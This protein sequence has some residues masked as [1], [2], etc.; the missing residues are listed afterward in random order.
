MADQHQRISDSNGKARMDKPIPQAEEAFQ[1]TLGQEQVGADTSPTPLRFFG[2]YELVEEIARGGMGVVYK[3]RQVS[4]NRVVALKMILTGQLASGADVVRFRTEAEAVASL[5]HP[6]IVSVYEVGT[7]EEQHYFTM[8]LIDGGS[9]SESLAKGRWSIGTREGERRAAQLMA[10]VA[11]AVH[12]AHQRGILHRDIKP[13]NILLDEFGHPHITDFGVAKRVEGGSDLTRSGAIVGTPSYMAPEQARAEKGLST[14]VD[15]YSLGAVLFELLTGRPPFKGDSPLNTLRQVLDCEPPRPRQIQP[16]LNRDLE[17]ICLKCLEKEAPQRYGSAEAF[18]E[19]LERWLAEEPIRAR[20]SK[21]WERALKWARR[22]P[23]VAALMTVSS[24]GAILMI[25]LLVVSYIVVSREKQKADDALERERRASYFQRILTA[26]Q[27]WSGNNIPQAEQFL[28][29]CHDDMKSW[30]WHYVKR[31]CHADLLTWQAP[32]FPHMVAGPWVVGYQWVEPGRQRTLA[33]FDAF[34]GQQLHVLPPIPEVVRTVALSPS[35]DRLAV[36]LI[37]LDE[38]A[39][40]RVA[41]WDLTTPKEISSFRCR[42]RRASSLAFTPDGRRLAALS[43]A[44]DLQTEVAIW[45]T[46]TG[47]R[48]CT[49]PGAFPECKVTFDHTGKRAIVRSDFGIRVFAADMGG[50]LFS[51][52]PARRGSLVSSVTLSPDGRAIAMAMNSG[53]I[54]EPQAQVALMDAATARERQRIVTGALSIHELVFSPNGKQLALACADAVVRLIDVS[55]GREINQ[56]RGHSAPIF[57]VSFS[58]DGRRLASVSGEGIVKV[59]D[60]RANQEYRALGALYGMTFTPDS[61]ML[62]LGGVGTSQLRWD[63]IAFYDAATGQPATGA[64]REQ[65][66]EVVRVAYSADQRYAGLVLRERRNLLREL[67]QRP[68]PRFLQVWDREANRAVAKLELPPKWDT[69]DSHLFLSPDGRYAG[70]GGG[71]LGEPIVM[72][73]IEPG[74]TSYSLPPTRCCPAFSPDSEWLAVAVGDPAVGTG[75]KPASDKAVAKEKPAPKDAKVH[76]PV[77]QICEAAT[78]RVRHELAGDFRAGSVAISPD[79][80]RVA[81]VADL[82]D[83]GPGDRLKKG[84]AVIWDIASRKQIVTLPGACDRVAFSPDNR[85]IATGAP[86][87]GTVRLWDAD[88]GQLVLVLRA[89]G[90]GLLTGLAFS[91]NG[92]YLAAMDDYLVHRVTLWDARPLSTEVAP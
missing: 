10:K 18:A 1:P 89:Q 19:D 87:G 39:P 5:D 66:L 29:D 74:R 57:R 21:P 56:F 88:T 54:S 32:D 27:A 45:N 51:C 22:R 28:S 4:L 3:A 72:F 40:D 91:P 8:K 52:S 70:T 86:E 48:L 41:V 23:A 71:K 49:L 20:P 67:A 11:R 36:S 62:A 63:G 81:A 90:N 44:G 59:W 38:E 15:V 17:T 34:T 68:A 79:G 53:D 69:K 84:K 9:L 16:R 2:D 26:Q 78:G 85:R 37:A 58:N 76:W 65:N 31:L 64:H 12:Y 7:H 80:K 30:E 14:G 24:L 47:K 43:E 92:H 50:Y 77:V 75:Q 55:S 35:G 82:P 83:P 6:Y 33:V 13:A 46:D 73:P 60:V 25:A 61:Q 42:F